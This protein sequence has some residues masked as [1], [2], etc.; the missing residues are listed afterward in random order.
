MLGDENDVSTLAWRLFQ[1]TGKVNYYL[2]YH[3][4]QESELKE[5]FEKR[6]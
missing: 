6:R 2:L 3:D 5:E 1:N 4:L